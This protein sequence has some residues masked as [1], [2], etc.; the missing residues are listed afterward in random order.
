MSEQITT[1]G[2]A[3]AAPLGGAAEVERLVELARSLVERNAQ[4]QQALDSRIVIEQAKGVLSERL[5]LGTDEAFL[6]LRRAARNNRL[7]IH[8]LAGKVVASRETPE[9]ITELLR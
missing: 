2:P 6:L 8:A 5:G 4:L 7:R 9:E 3:V 1:R